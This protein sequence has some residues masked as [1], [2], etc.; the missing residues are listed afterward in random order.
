[1][2]KLIY[3][4]IT[5]LDGYV[6]DE[7]GEFGWAAPDEDVHAFVNDRERGIGT[8]LYGRRMYEVM[9]FWETADLDGEPAVFRDYAAIWRAAGKVVYST[10]LPA[11]TTER[12]RLERRFDPAAVRELTD[13]GDVS[14]GGPHLAA[15]ALRA[16][17]VDECH[18]YLNPVVVGGGTRALPD[19]VRLDL[20]MVDEHRF[21]NGVVH[22]AYRAR[23]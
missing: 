21:G 8:F 1:M 17:L 13:G 11:V 3:S 18:L 19:G 10:T 20:D 2:G 23:R 5:S 6:A 12:T 16:G 4:A 7:R 14:I 22:L 9:R 15:H